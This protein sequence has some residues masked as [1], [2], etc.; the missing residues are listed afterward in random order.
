MCALHIGLAQRAA[1]SVALQADQVNGAEGL[2]YLLQ[3]RLLR[4]RCKL[5]LTVPVMTG[6]LPDAAHAAGNRMYLCMSDTGVGQALVARRAW[7]LA[8]RLV[9]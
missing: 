8:C 4:G 6:L 1:G 5:L 7:M 2:E 3:V 9:M